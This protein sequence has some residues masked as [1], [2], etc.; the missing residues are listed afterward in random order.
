VGL[1]EDVPNLLHGGEGNSKGSGTIK[2]STYTP[3]PYQ[4]L[5]HFPFAGTRN[6]GKQRNIIN[7]ETNKK[8]NIFSQLKLKN[9]LFKRTKNFL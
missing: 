2:Y 5:L 4:D 8:G 9:S 1:L 7:F 6:K 3:A